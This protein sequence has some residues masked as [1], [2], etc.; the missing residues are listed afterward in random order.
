MFRQRDVLERMLA[1]AGITING[2]NPWDLH[3]RNDR[4]VPRLLQNKSVG[5]TGGA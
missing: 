2:N 5:P 4:I 1:T 3:V